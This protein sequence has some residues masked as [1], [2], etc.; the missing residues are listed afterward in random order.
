MTIHR[1]GRSCRSLTHYTE[2]LVIS[3]SVLQL[4]RLPMGGNIFFSIIILGSRVGERES[5][6]GSKVE[7]GDGR[8]VR[9]LTFLA[10]KVALS[11]LVI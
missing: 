1:L 7:G 6:S 10:A 11:A 8:S 2:T 4:K 9:V 5:R 3:R